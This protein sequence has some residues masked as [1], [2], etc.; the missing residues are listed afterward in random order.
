VAESDGELAGFRTFVRWEF[1]H[2]D[3]RVR[4]AV[5]AVDTATHPA[6]Q[7]Q[8]IFTRLTRA[9]LDELR[10]DGVDFVFN[11][12]NDK[13]RPGYLKMGWSE[14]GRLPVR[15]RPSGP[16]A[17]WRM[18]RAR[19]PAGKWSLPCTAGWA[20]VDVFADAGVVDLLASQPPAAGLRTRRTVEQLRWRYGLEP[21][22]YR[23]VTAGGAASRGLLVFR[24]RPRGSAVEVVVADVLARGGDAAIERAL[25]RELRRLKLGDYL[26]G[27]D[28]R[29]RPPGGFVP[30]PGQGPILTWRSVTET[31]AP[32]LADWDLHLGDIE[33]F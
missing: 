29:R 27:V 2:P 8:G 10:D 7:G 24:L 11:T 19:V 18:A 25:V 15:V 33:L 20:P 3:G 14:V 30:L 16:R 4:R 12:P 22:H 26:I 31:D 6:F 5:R 21:L 1:E 28:R 32:D 17:L 9:A 23:V 13:S